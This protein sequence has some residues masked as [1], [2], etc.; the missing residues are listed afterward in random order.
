MEV[1]E[2]RVSGTTAVAGV[3][4]GISYDICFSFEAGAFI[5]ESQDYGTLGLPTVQRKQVFLL[6]YAVIARNLIQQVPLLFRIN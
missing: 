6:S 4:K 3:K 5:A 1:C 2:V